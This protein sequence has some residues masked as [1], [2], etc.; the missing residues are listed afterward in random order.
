MRCDL[1]G[2]YV[3]KIVS[4]SLALKFVAFDFLCTEGVDDFDDYNRGFGVGVSGVF[5][6]SLLGFGV[7]FGGFG[8]GASGVV[9][10]KT[11]VVI[12][13]AYVHLVRP[14]FLTI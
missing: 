7:S 14:D 1:L 2:T 4:I 11:G 5:G 8:T 12:V 10:G 9:L 6:F 13:G 3:G